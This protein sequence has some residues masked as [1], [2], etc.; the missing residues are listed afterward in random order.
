MRKNR[1]VLAL[2]FAGP[3]LSALTASAQTSSPAAAPATPEP[4]SLGVVTVTANRENTLLLQTPASV[5]VIGTRAIQRTGPMHPQ[6]ILNQVPG[7][8]STLQGILRG[9]G[10]TGRASSAMPRTSELSEALRR[11][12]ASTAAAGVR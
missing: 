7:V 11:F 8:G 12:E 2:A 6:Q 9:H 5:G 1:V 3:I 4:P 10:F